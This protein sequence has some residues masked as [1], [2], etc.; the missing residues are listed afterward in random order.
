MPIN[1][2]LSRPPDMKCKL[3]VVGDGGCG[4]TCML[5]AYA[6]NHFPEVY[7]PTVFEN[8]VIVLSFEGKSVELALC[9]TA[10]QGEYDRLRPLLYPDSDM[11]L[12][13]FS[14]DS[15]VSLANV[16][17]KWCPEVFHF[18]RG[19]PMLLVGTK[20]D[21]R[22][23]EQT[24][25]MLSAQGLTTVTAEQGEAAAQKIGATRYMECSAKT[26]KGVQDIFDAAIKWRVRRREGPICTKGQ[27][28]IL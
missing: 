25:R 9:D 16:Q 13:V 2:A 6:E 15:H 26:G 18:C 12:I 4:K 19:T 5:I 14:I 20:T 21:L 24:Q 27:C 8:H 7:A 28:V 1:R 17:D 22:A 11:I 10:G 23:D 3:V